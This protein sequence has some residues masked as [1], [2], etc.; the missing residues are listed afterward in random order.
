VIFHP[1][2]SA[3]N[4]WYV[5]EVAPRSARTY[6]GYHVL[7]TTASVE[8]IKEDIAELKAVEMV[9]DAFGIATCYGMRAEDLQNETEDISLN[10][11]LY[12]DIGS[13]V[14]LCEHESEIS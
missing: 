9:Q 13:Y 7:I 3:S 6:E 1:T 11:E 12:I 5:I 14:K 2:K 10:G 4:W 8:E